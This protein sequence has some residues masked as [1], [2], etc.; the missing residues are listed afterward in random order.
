MPLFDPLSLLYGLTLSKPETILAFA[1]CSLIVVM[2]CGGIFDWW[3][4]NAEVLVEEP[5]TPPHPLSGSG[6]FCVVIMRECVGVYGW[7]SS[8]SGSWGGGVIE[9]SFFRREP[10][11]DHG[12]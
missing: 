7:S 6:R 4:P 5:P 9:D 2:V 3:F 11:A 10:P 1:L 12:P 8:G